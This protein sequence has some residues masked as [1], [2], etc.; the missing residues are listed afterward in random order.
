MNKLDRQICKQILMEDQDIRDSLSLGP[1]PEVVAPI[2]VKESGEVQSVISVR[3]KKIIL[4]R[5]DASNMSDE[6][7][8]FCG[9]DN[10]KGER[11]CPEHIHVKLL[12]PI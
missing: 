8:Q 2:K 7:R 1:K 9:K 4:C 11:Y 3:K 5:Y 6:K 12:W 10:I